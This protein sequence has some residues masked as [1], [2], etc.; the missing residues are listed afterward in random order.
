MC[1]E[2][3]GQVL[4]SRGENAMASSLHRRQTEEGLSRKSNHPI[5]ELLLKRSSSPDSL[6]LTPISQ[7]AIQLERLLVPHIPHHNLK[8]GPISDSHMRC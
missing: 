7:V 6:P 5:V 2:A 1:K 3:W 8:L 4:E